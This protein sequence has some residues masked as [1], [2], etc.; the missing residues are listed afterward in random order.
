MD[1]TPAKHRELVAELEQTAA[2]PRRALAGRGARLAAEAAPSWP[3]VRAAKAGLA[4]L[5]RYRPRPG[6]AASTAAGRAPYPTHLRTQVDAYLDG[7][8]FATE[9]ATAG[10]EEAMRYSLLAG[11]KRIRPVLALAT[12]QRPGRARGGTAARRR[13]GADPHLLADPRRPAGDGRRRP[14][15][16]PPDLPRQ[17][18]RGRRDPRRRR[19]L[20]G[21]VPARPAR[22]AGEPANLL[23][24]VA[25]S[26]PRRASTGW[27]A[28][29]T[30]TSR[31]FVARGRSDAAP[32]ARAQDRPADRRVRGMRTPVDQAE[33]QASTLPHFRDFAAELGVLFQ[34]VDDILD[35]TGTDDALGKP[36]GSDERHGKLTYVT[37]YGLDGAREMAAES[38][39]N[40]RVALAQPRRAAPRS[41][42]ASPTSSSPAPHDPHPRPHRPPAAT[43]TASP[44]TSSS[45]S[46]RRSA[47]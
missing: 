45:R 16:R 41:S 38:H 27:S 37:P 30:S 36:R 34:I 5:G 42:S 6:A 8:R 24:A 19:P 18:R 33:D 12:A 15:P 10:L 23:A 32:A 31:A 3:P 7:L 17:V 1:P 43:S 28:A 20:R 22:A 40:A 26:P 13:A 2:R 14:A 4:P 44:T 25:S 9:P 11:G 47:S 35:V 21:G 39:R 46:P 29:S